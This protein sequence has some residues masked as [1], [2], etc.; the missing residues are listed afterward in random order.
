MLPVRLVAVLLAHS[1]G[2][3]TEI[4]AVTGTGSTLMVIVALLLGQVVPVLIV[5]TNT[6]LLPVPMPVTGLVARLML[7]ILAEPD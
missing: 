2:L 7:P 4:F 6:L 3:I 5:H 1:V